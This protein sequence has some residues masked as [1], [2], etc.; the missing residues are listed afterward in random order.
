MADSKGLPQKREGPVEGPDP[1]RSKEEKSNDSASDEEGKVDARCTPEE[2]VEIRRITKLLKVAYGDAAKATHNPLIYGRVCPIPWDQIVY[3]MKSGA[4]KTLANRF[5]TEEGWTAERM[6]KTIGEAPIPIALPPLSREESR[7][8]FQSIRYRVGI[9]ESYSTAEFDIDIPETWLDTKFQGKTFK[10]S[11]AV[12]YGKE[13]LAVVAFNQRKFLA[14]K[15]FW[16]RA[17]CDDLGWELS[18]AF[19]DCFYI[20]LFVI[21]ADE[22]LVMKSTKNIKKTWGVSGVPN[23]VKKAFRDAAKDA[24]RA[25]NIKHKE[26]YRLLKQLF[27]A[28]LK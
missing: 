17:L 7:A 16:F 20:I 24:E 19:C 4:T 10:K 28:A 23:Q 18:A 5:L 3:Y 9:D 26:T 11:N 15:P 14:K 21:C 8:L 27:P 1:K 12:A 13:I 25:N 6:R 2:I 22:S